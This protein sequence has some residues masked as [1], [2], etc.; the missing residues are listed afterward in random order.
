VN[1]I[2]AL[3][4]AAAL[5]VSGSAFAADYAPAPY[6]APRPHAHRAPR[7]S[8]YA[9]PPAIR[10]APPVY[11]VQAPPQYVQRLVPVRGCGGCSGG[12]AAV[13]TWEQLPPPGPW[14]QIGD[15]GY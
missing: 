8:Y 13:G 1:I 3:A 4:A 14:D 12:Y 6:Y 11:W 5:V 10:Q 15:Y 7:I 9:P 2:K